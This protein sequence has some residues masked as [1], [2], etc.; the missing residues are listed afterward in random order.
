MSPSGFP[1]IYGT[2]DVVSRSRLWIS[3]TH[4][5]A[6][7]MRLIK[8]DIRWCYFTFQF[9]LFVVIPAKKKMLWPQSGA[10]YVGVRLFLEFGN[11]NVRIG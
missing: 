2:W 5:R 4:G 1:W 8:L 7:D 3:S 6:H 10:S 9:D 11:N